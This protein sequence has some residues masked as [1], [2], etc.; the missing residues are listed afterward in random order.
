[1]GREVFLD[2]RYKIGPLQG[3]NRMNL[4]RHE[5]NFLIVLSALLFIGSLVIYLKQ[6]RPRVRITVVEDSLKE[7]LT[8]KE[9]EAILKEKR[10]IDIN[11]AKAE[12]LVVIPGIGQTLALRIVGY[13]NDHGS[14]E[15]KE[16][17]LNVEGIGPA[18]LEKIKEYIKIE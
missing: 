7:E 12:E 5:K 17:I 1:M 3:G 15:T 11:N 4:T 6:S 18:K 10:K 8:L 13:R 16:D 14:F 2:N 9:V